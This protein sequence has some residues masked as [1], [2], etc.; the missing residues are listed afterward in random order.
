MCETG[1]QGVLLNFRAQSLQQALGNA[2]CF[3]WF[4]EKSDSILTSCQII[5]TLMPYHFC[6]T[7]YLSVGI[8]VVL[9]WVYVKKV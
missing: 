8:Q 7:P 4:E 5:S 3:S 9:G 1:S 6:P 2:I